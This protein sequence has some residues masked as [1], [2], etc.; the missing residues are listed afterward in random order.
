MAEV[1]LKNPGPLTIS[2][3]TKGISAVLM[4]VGVAAFAVALMTNKERAWHAYLTGYFYFFIL[5]IGGLFF[6]AVNAVAKAGW[7]VNVRRFSESLTAFLPV[8]FVGALVLLFGGHSLYEWMD[9]AHVQSVTLL[10]IRPLTEYAF[11][12][13]PH[14][15]LFCFV[16][17]VQKQNYW[18]IARPGSL[19]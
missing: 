17:A 15:D 16:D 11:L 14:G 13:Y 1:A 2:S 4:F 12:R 9:P 18:R 19:G 3:R 5:G 10:Q 7:I 8:A 6:A